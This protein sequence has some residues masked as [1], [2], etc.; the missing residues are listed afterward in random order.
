[1]L[2]RCRYIQCRSGD[3]YMDEDEGQN[4]E[5]EVEP[6]SDEEFSELLAR[7][8]PARDTSRFDR[9]IA[10]TVALQNRGRI[11]ARAGE[12]ERGLKNNISRAAS[13]Q[14]LKADWLAPSSD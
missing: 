4:Q 1:M 3:R 10:D 5:S 7:S 12:G 14:N 9:I 8:R 2:K 6:I 11:R 13:R